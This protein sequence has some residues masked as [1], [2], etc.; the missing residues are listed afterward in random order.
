M[1][2]SRNEQSRKKPNRRPLTK[3]GDKD[4]ADKVAE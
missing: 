1:P 3:D 4:A 2:I